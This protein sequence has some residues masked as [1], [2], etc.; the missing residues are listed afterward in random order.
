VIVT[1][2]GVENVI[3]PNRE[4]ENV[5]FMIVINKIFRFSLLHFQVFIR[6]EHFTSKVELNPIV[7]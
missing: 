2:R 1:N 4:V 7:K 5:I 3:I 6:N